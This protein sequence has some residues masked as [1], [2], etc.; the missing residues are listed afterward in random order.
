MEIERT[1]LQAADLCK[2]MLAY[3]GQGKV[4]TR[5]LD[6]NRM[7]RD[8][9]QLL[10]ISVAKKVQLS[11]DLAHTLPLI[12]GDASQ[13][14]QVLVNLIINASEAIVDKEGSIWVSTGVV[15]G[16]KHL[17]EGTAVTGRPQE[18]DY[19]FV[20]IADTGCGMDEETR[21]RIFDPFFTTKFTGRGLG[22]A[23][24]L[25]IVR[26]HDGTLELTTNQGEGTTFTLLF[27]KAD[28]QN[29]APLRD[30]DTPA[31]PCWSGSGL[32]LVVD[33]EESVRTLMSRMLE[34]FHFHVIEAVDGRDA[35]EKFC[36]H[37]DAITAVL[38]DVTMP[39]MSGLEAFDQIR[40]LRPDVPVLFMS[41]YMSEGEL[42][43]LNGATDFIQKP[44]KLDEF[45]SKLR[46]LLSPTTDYH[47]G[48]V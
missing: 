5:L 12:Q 1:S 23:A 7:V 2:Q 41:G 42:R 39:V 11:F 6:L 47:H 37:A 17:F 28:A 34:S 26:S 33:D 29:A 21:T 14:R 10:R 19:V 16:A 13:I 24:V 36:A 46:M 35:V 45:Q 44:F 8:M 22:L 30:E 3:S 48:L 32:V 4:E 43:N 38:L 9:S 27:P 15:H 40:N 25:G 18:R 31:A 20:S